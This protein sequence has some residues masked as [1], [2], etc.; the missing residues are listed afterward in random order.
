MTASKLPEYEISILDYLSLLS[1]SES[2]L[3]GLPRIVLTKD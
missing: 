3:K 2:I 1:I